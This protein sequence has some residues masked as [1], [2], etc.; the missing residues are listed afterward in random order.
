MVTI[1]DRRARHRSDRLAYDLYIWQLCGSR[2]QRC[3]KLGIGL[4]QE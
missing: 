1:K 2:R 4:D 3:R